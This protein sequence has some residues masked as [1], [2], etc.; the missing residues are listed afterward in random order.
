MKILALT[1]LCIAIGLFSAGCAR[2]ASGSDN[3]TGRL[4]ILN[5]DEYSPYPEA[6]SKMLPGY[7]AERASGM[8]FRRLREGTASEAFAAQ[9]V[10][11]L[12]TGAAKHWYPQYLATA[13]IAA[14]R[15]KTDADIRGWRDLATAD[16]A[17]G[18]TDFPQFHNE[19]LLAAVS[20][21]LEGEN[22]SLKSAAK[23]LGAINDEGRLKR[24][25]FDAPVLI[26]FDYSAADLIKKG[27]NLEI[28][29][30]EEG[31]LSYEK[32]LLSNEPLSFTGNV[33]E[34]LR[35]NGFR[36]LD[37][38]RD[39]ALYPD[40]LD[41]GKASGVKDYNHLNDVVLDATRVLR[42]DVLHVRLY[43]SAD[44]REHQYWVLHF[45][46]LLVIWVASI[47][48]RAVQKCVRS[49]ALLAGLILF[50]WVAARLIKYQ[51]EPAGLFNLTFLWYSYYLFQLALPLLIL[52]L[53]WAI[54]KPEGSKPPKRL[55]AIFAV[56]GVLAAL[57]QSNNLHNWVFRIGAVIQGV[58]LE[59]T[60]GV[61][62]YI[63]QAGCWLPLISGIFMMLR[64]SG[65]S[66]RKRGAVFPV[67][68][69]ILLGLYVAGYAARVPVAWESDV[70]MVIAAFTL[71]F[72]EASIRSGLIPVNSKYNTLF[73]HSTLSLQIADRSGVVIR[74]SAAADNQIAGTVAAALD[75]YPAPARLDE[76][77]LC[78]ASPITGGYA[79]WREDITG[80]NR[81]HKEV[82]E[83]VAKQEAA[84]RLLAEEEQL[85]RSIQDEKEKARLSA[86]LE[87]EIYSHTLRLNTM[88]ERLEDP[89]NRPK[90]VARITLL[91]C[92][93]K[94]RCNLFFLEEETDIFPSDK[95]ALYLDELMEIAAYSGVK[96]IVTVE[97]GI[98]LSVRRAT[99][100]Y[101]FFYSVAH[102]AASFEDC[103]LIARFGWE[104]G[105]VSLRIL[106]SEDAGLFTM[107]PH[108]L[109]AIA[110]AGG[111]YSIKDLD[112]ETAGVSLSFPEGGQ[113]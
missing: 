10:S 13:V 53:A 109:S 95:L 76:N 92:Y 80:L 86:Q 61:A 58:T 29:L 9:A 2:N 21:G 70:T 60:Y 81:L 23:L 82:A 36:L 38:T 72:F 57:V 44:G 11:A 51:L 68:L 56:N 52:W 112:D 87:K 37:G 43:S 105:K 39:P 101:D 33:S 62:F 98:D 85:K 63:V 73:D 89:D 48:H 17:I 64:K 79:V 18:Y 59:Y 25:D 6:V 94:R 45:I 42:R 97:P 14:D 24:G 8:I 4:V 55:C 90:A 93:I 67:A 7:T 22:F 30:P 5:H 16:E 84:N 49:A 35:S 104:D 103:R 3:K 69:F 20:Y 107:E 75:A 78:F 100:L 111:A 102:W 47:I 96:A 99:L 32:G 26:C 106:P 46:V 12:E 28:I 77:V 88:I 40:T 1:F 113:P 110:V 54:D 31:T 15:D 50:G 65:G 34:L 41:Y 19:M 27:R 83:S 91:L 66:M 108:L 71:L 74:A